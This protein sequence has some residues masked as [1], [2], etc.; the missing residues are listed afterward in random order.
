VSEPARS[1]IEDPRGWTSSRL[2]ASLYD[3]EHDGF[4]ADAELYAQLARRTDGPVLELACG[5]GRV[6]AP[7]VE[8]KRDV[9]GV[10][11][12]EAML[13][14]AWA[15]LGRS[16]KHVCLVK[17]DLSLDFEA[18]VPERPYGLIILAL[19]ALGLVAASAQ[20]RKLLTALRRRL[21]PDGVVA[22]DVVHVAPLFDEPQGLPVLQRSGEAEGIG[23]TVV[24]WMVR[25]IRPATQQI[26]L[27]SI[28]DL[29]W[30]DGETRRLSEPLTLRYFARY[31]LE[32]VLG[33][34]GLEVQGM[35]G[36]YELGEFSDE[37]GRLIAFAGPGAGRQ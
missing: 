4:S 19:D 10:D 24:K 12:A 9:V 8:A 16:S 1:S 6:L 11:R 18:R 32:Y 2:L 34:A 28:Y 36:D 29:T 13:E 21:A 22:I 37:S 25:R 15:R 5:T 3:W 33:D 31:E 23:A 17:A 27:L 30:P 14:R 20:H 26:E 7:L 35:Y